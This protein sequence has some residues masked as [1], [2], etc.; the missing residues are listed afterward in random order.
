MLILLSGVKWYAHSRSYIDFSD[1]VIHM[2]AQIDHKLRCKTL[3]SLSFLPLCAP[4]IIY[5]SS[6]SVMLAETC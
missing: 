1:M 6:C 5:A 3:V 2:G 4:D